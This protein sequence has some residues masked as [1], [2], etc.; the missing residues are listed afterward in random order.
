MF[1]TTDLSLHLLYLLPNHFGLK[2]THIT[3]AE[4]PVMGICLSIP[5]GPD[6]DDRCLRDV[7][8]NC[9]IWCWITD[10]QRTSWLWHD[11]VTCCSAKAMLREWAATLGDRKDMDAKWHCIINLRSGE[12]VEEN[13]VH[14]HSWEE[15]IDW[16]AAESNH[17]EI[18]LRAMRYD[19]SLVKHQ[20]RFRGMGEETVNKLNG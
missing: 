4:F 10:L 8:K 17:Q 6:A 5:C 2:E 9:L 12:S 20:E 19:R 13:H 14:C 16:A 15:G 18:L 7:L 1:L 11:E 3:S